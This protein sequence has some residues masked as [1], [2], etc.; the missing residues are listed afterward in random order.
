MQLEN[1]LKFDRR[2]FKEGREFNKIFGVPLI[3]YWH[4]FC[5]FDIIKFTDEVVVRIC[6]RDDSKNMEEVVMEKWGI[7][8]VNL[9]NRLIV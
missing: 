3:K 2:I 8:A 5:G 4:P 7:S 6:R 1:V 9:I